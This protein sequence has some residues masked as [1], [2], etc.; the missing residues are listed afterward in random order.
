MN[1]FDIIAYLFRI[2]LFLIGLFVFGSMAVFFYLLFFASE[3]TEDF[4]I[5]EIISICSMEN[6]QSCNYRIYTDKQ[7]IFLENNKT[8]FPDIRATLLKAAEL[9]QKCTIKT[10]NDFIHEVRSC[11]NQ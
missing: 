9:K 6:S 11:N 4:T 1:F 8:N 5:K 3:I 10:K 2:G 7:I